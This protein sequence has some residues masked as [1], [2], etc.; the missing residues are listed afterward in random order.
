MAFDLKNRR[1]TYHK[2]I[3]IILESQIGQNI[4][5]YIDDVIVK[6]EKCGDLDDLK[7]T[8]NNLRKY[9]M[10]LNPKK[11][12]FGVSYGKL[13]GYLVFAQGIDANPNKVE[14]IAQL[15]PPRT[16]RETQKLA[17]MM[18]ALNRFISKLGECGMPSYK[19]L[20]KTDGFQWDDQTMVT[21]IELKQYLKSLPTLVPL[22]EDVL[23]LYVAATDVVVGTIIVVERPEANTEVKH[24]S[25]YFF[26]EILKDA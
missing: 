3:H 19:L 24:Q 13:L 26:S 1:D 5:S 2:G 23:L 9:K 4:E 11:Y 14:A 25:V 8:F 10:M 18:A 21:F 22:K 17:C 15:H 7:E 6:S 20:R 12:V 16:Q